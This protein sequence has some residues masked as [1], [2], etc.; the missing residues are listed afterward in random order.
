MIGVCGSL[1]AFNKP[2]IY[3]S[4]ER[5]RKFIG[6][7]TG[8]TLLDLGIRMEAYCISGIDRG[9]QMYL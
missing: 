9:Y 6:D 8:T 2:V 3:Y 7:L 5:V 1:A 4:N